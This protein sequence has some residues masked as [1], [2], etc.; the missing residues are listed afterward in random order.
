M[1]KPAQ[2][3]RETL[4]PSADNPAASGDSLAN[5][6]D[7]DRVGRTT[8]RSFPEP[9]APETG[10]S[11]GGEA[12][13]SLST[14]PNSKQIGSPKDSNGEGSTSA[15]PRGDRGTVWLTDSMAPGRIFDVLS[16][17]EYEAVGSLESEHGYPPIG[18]SF[19]YVEYCDQET[20]EKL[21]ALV[22]CLPF[23]PSSLR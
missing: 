21:K 6:P 22:R 9:D 19:V 17:W 5:T 14:T 23:Y 12:T 2:V 11:Q 18:I 7:V 20:M 4:P 15:P 1:G 16:G 10:K 13:N 3:R 8:S